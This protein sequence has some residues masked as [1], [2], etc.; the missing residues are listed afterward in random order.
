MAQSTNPLVGV[1]EGIS[2]M[3]GTTEGQPPAA[4]EFLIVS[5]D[6]YF[7]ESELP[8]GRDKV[9]DLLWV[10]AADPLE[11]IEYLARKDGGVPNIYDLQAGDQFESL[12]PIGAGVAGDRG[13]SM[14]LV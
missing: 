13:L 8:D 12:R 2:L 9:N 14:P 10:Q 7:S 1:W 11:A 3:R 4:P 5:A 6:G